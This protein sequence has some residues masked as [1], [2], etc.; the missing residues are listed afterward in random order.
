MIGMGP[1]EAMKDSD[2]MST[3][4]EA[5]QRRDLFERDLRPPEIAH[6]ELDPALQQPLVRRDASRS[7]EGGA[8]R[9]D[10]HSAF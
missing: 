3:T 9:A 6:C 1:C 4:R 2:E 7:V 8:K 5:T 10:A